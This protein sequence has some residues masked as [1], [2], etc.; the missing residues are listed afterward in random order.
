MRIFDQLGPHQVLGDTFRRAPVAQWHPSHCGAL[1]LRI[2]RHGIWWHE[3]KPIRRQSLIRVLAS[4]L[5]YE[6]NQWWLKS[7]V[8]QLSIEVE[9]APFL[10]TECDIVQDQIQVTTNVGEILTLHSP[11]Q[12]T[13]DP[14][15]E[16]RP[17]ISLH[18]DVGARLS[19]TLFLHLIDQALAQ[20]VEPRD[21][22]LYWTAGSLSLP[23]GEL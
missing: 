12:L 21:G 7:P 19:R 3:G 17:W 22:I 1:D 18:E 10:I 16:L 8:E 20:T 5:T 11:W 13:T 23:M 2:D 6:D 4:V 9:D 14:D 15:G